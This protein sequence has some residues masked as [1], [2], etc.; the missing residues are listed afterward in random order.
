MSEV[1]AISVLVVGAVVL[2][3][4]GRAAR[5]VGLPE[6]VGFGVA[7]CVVG[8]VA[9]LSRGSWQ[10][11]LA[12]GSGGD[13]LL[14]YA[15]VTGLAGMLFITGSRFEFLKVWKARRL[16]ATLVIVSIL[17][18]ALAII[19]LRAFGWQEYGPILVTASAFAV[20]SVWLPA[21]LTRRL[22]AIDAEVAGAKGAGAL[23]AALAILVIH[24]FAVFAAIGDARAT[25]AVYL[26]V[27]LY[28]ALKLVV[29][30]SFAYFVTSRFLARAEG[31]ISSGRASI[32][33]LLIAA[34]VSVLAV[35]TSSLPVSLAWAFAAG[36]IWRRSAA[37]RR[38]SES[39][40]PIATA[41]LLSLIFIPVL[42]QLHGRSLNRWAPLV[43]FVFA[44]LIVKF[45]IIWTSGRAMNLRGR[46]AVQLG[47]LMLPPGEV[48]VL[49]LGYGV[50][51]W[52]IEAPFYLGLLAFT[53][54][55]AL[56]GPFIWHIASRTED[57][58]RSTSNIALSRRQR[59]GEA[60]GRHE[61]KLSRQRITNKAE[62]PR[63]TRGGLV[64]ERFL[65]KR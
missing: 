11:W 56:L 60:R 61:H 54:L 32:A 9:A 12:G 25:A 13:R 7:L 64:A 8:V 39:E 42:M 22:R 33:Y 3:G 30:F 50:T 65:V 37:G 44:G 2:L 47:G 17:L 31:R 38:L 29:F 16:A 51:R 10:T 27:T 59:V 40:S 19:L 45:A 52:A 48:A 34:L 35:M 24:F 15:R 49:L 57:V 23:L 62:R 26:I 41:V 28:E 5:R 21:A 14:T 4:I 63:T 36:A 20:V 46:E 6:A 58:A 43:V 53:F 55:S 1:F 18:L